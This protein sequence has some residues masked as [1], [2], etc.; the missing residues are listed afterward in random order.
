MSKG[1]GGPENRIKP[2][3][4]QEALRC[5]KNSNSE[6]SSRYPQEQGDLEPKEPYLPGQHCLYPFSVLA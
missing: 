3:V 2:S 6:L 4:E 1:A 5:I